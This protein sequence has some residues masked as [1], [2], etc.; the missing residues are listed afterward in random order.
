[1]TRQPSF[2]RGFT[3]A[4]QGIVPPKL[5]RSNSLSLWTG[6]AGSLSHADAGALDTNLF[7]MDSRV[8]V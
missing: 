5:D 1:M 7:M 6:T 8:S 3:Q 4:I 2:G